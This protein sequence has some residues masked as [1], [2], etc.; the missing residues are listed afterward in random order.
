MSN[1]VEVDWQ[2]SIRKDKANGIIF[3]IIQIPFLKLFYFIIKP[4]CR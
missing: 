2:P 3:L 4:Y 1:L